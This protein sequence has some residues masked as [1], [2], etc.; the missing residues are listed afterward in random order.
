M[1]GMVY[2][3]SQINRMLKGKLDGDPAF[4]DVFV[5]GEISNFTHHMKTGT[6]RPPSRPL[7][8]NG[9]PAACGSCPKTA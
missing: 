5:R 2:T 6:S 4:Q 3:V 1:T 9:T 7:C 8:S